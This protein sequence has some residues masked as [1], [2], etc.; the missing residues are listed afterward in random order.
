MGRWSERRALA[1]END[2][3]V[4]TC[5]TLDVNEYLISEWPTLTLKQRRAVWYSC[6]TDDDFDWSDIE[7]QID[8]MVF[9]LAGDNDTWD[10]GEASLDDD[11]D[12]DD[13]D[14]DDED[15]DTI[16]DHLLSYAT[17]LTNLD[18]ENFSDEFLNKCVAALD[19][20]I[21]EEVKDKDD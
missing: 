16:Y 4:D 6:Q 9:E 15:P 3:T 11:E 13:D 1:A 12:D 7:D 17:E 10:L 19:A 21:K 2:E 20:M 18:H 5:L 14:E 8:D